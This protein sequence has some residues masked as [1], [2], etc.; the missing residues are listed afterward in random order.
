MS[1]D[2]SFKDILASL[3]GRGDAMARDVLAWSAINS[4]TQNLP[5]LERVAGEV[6]PQFEAAGFEARTLP[7]SEVTE[8]DADGREAEIERGPVHVLTARP[9]A[10]RRVLMTGHLDTVFPKTADFQRAEDRGDGTL[11]GPGV[12]DMKGGIR[13]MLEAASTFLKTPYADEVGIDVV[14]NSDEETGS[15]ASAS[16]LHE[17][18]L[19][20][21][22]GLVYEPAL[23]DGT[24]AGARAG[25]G[26]YTFTV[27]GLAAHA[28]REFEKGRNAILGAAR[29]MGA[30]DRLNGQRDGVTLN[31]GVIG[32]GQATN[33][34]PDLCLVRMNVRGRRTEDLT[35]V[36]AQ[37]RRTVDEGNAAEGFGAGIRVELHGGVHRPVKEMRGGTAMLFDAVRQAGSSLGIGIDWAPT[38]GCCDGNNLAAAGLPNVDTLGVVGGK[39]HSDQE[40][41]VKDSFVP[42]AKLSLLL[43][44]LLG[45]GQVPW[46]ARLD[47]EAA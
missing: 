15:H 4:G 26:H 42:R 37:I 18:A 41:T 47:A 38:G 2:P 23:P 20:A 29:L 31:L 35:W 19:A 22:I 17:R 5:G 14:L 43:L 13:V 27:R 28:G 16:V 46:P 32:G 1:L 12:A 7:P 30:I 9:E 8:I 6:L 33:V 44:M 21:D 45:S 36:D 25:S 11:H 34:V 3:D 10:K 40:Y 24:L 39:I